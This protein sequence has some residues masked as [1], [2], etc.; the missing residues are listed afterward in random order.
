MGPDH[1][2]GSSLGPREVPNL[3]QKG[4]FG[5][6]DMLAPIMLIDSSGGEATEPVLHVHLRGTD[7]LNNPMLNK[8][9][10][11]TLE[12]RQLLGLEGLLPSR[13]LTI[14]E[15]MELELEHLARKDDDLERYI[16]LASLQDRN[17]TLFHRLLLDHPDELLPIVYTPV[18]GRACQEYSRI[19]R[20]PRGI[21]ITPDGSPPM[22][23]PR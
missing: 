21:W 17:E 10:A 19:M 13:V 1:R 5:R 15:Q 9:R 20:R 22:D 2:L 14:E 12:E 4:T 3:R 8:G 23:H 11:F 6:F 18:V 16:G 7:L